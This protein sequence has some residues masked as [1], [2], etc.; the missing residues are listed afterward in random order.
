MFPPKNEEHL[1]KPSV[2]GVLN[3][4]SGNRLKTSLMVQKNNYLWEKLRITLNFISSQQVWK[5]KNAEEKFWFDVNNF[6]GS[7]QWNGTNINKNGL[8]PHNEPHTVKLNFSCI[9]KVFSGN[10]LQTSLWG[11]KLTISERSKELFR[12]LICPNK[13]KKCH[14]PKKHFDL[15]GTTFFV[16]TSEIG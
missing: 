6:L 10:L 13:F 12:K 15:R 7:T 4:F 2:S 1:A 14:I 3:H 11:Q 9:L 16:Q 5:G 8:S